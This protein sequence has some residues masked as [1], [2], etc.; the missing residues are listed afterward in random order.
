MKHPPL[1]RQ[2]I[3]LSKTTLIF[4]IIF[5]LVSYGI[6]ALGYLFDYYLNL[7]P[8]LIL[9]VVGTMF[10]SYVFS[11]ISLSR[12]RAASYI[13]FP[14][15]V[16]SFIIKS[17]F[18]IFVTEVSIQSESTVF[19]VSTIFVILTLIF[20]IMM[21]INAYKADEGTM[22]EHLLAT[23]EV[24]DEETLSRY[25]STF[26]Y[27]V[28]FLAVIFIYIIVGEINHPVYLTTVYLFFLG[29]AFLLIIKA[30]EKLDYS[31]NKSMQAIIFG[32][33]FLLI[34]YAVRMLDIPY[35]NHII[36]VTV[37]HILV[38]TPIFKT[39]Y[40]RYD[41]IARHYDKIALTEEI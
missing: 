19:I 7:S 17:V 29:S 40:Y 30:G 1:K 14:F 34:A 20:D 28:R 41:K 25:L 2:L 3:N 37:I 27:H 36:P 12:S 13:T 23:N 9:V 31:D 39:L 11:S 16:A 24:L 10:L 22:K 26:K 5:Y 15:G 33:V 6:M 35:L 32:T 4:T 38:F 8:F 18:Y 21:L